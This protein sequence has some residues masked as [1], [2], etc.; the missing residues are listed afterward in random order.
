[1][2]KTASAL[3]TRDGV[4]IWPISDGPPSFAGYRYRPDGNDSHYAT[5]QIFQ[6]G[7]PENVRMIISDQ[8]SSRSFVIR[9]FNI[10]RLKH[11]A[12]FVAESLTETEIQSAQLPLNSNGRVICKG[13][14]ESVSKIDDGYMMQLAGGFNGCF[15][16]QP[17]KLEGELRFL[18]YAID[19]GNLSG[20]QIAPHR[21]HRI[22]IN[23]LNQDSV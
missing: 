21:A 10:N 14:V 12:R 11:G 15:I 23:E 20:N 17:I 22:R 3:A 6:S 13:S 9:Q 16:L 1:L 4:L 5:F 8:I 19:N 2:V 7:G 18:F